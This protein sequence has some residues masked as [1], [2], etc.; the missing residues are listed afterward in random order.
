MNRPT[1]LLM[2]FLVTSCASGGE[3]IQQKSSL[4]TATATKPMDTNSS[5]GDIRVS[6]EL[7]TINLD[8]DD[9]QSVS[10][11][12]DRKLI[13]TPFKQFFLIDLKSDKEEAAVR[14]GKIVDTAL[15]TKNINYEIKI[16]KA[17]SAGAEQN[18]LIKLRSIHVTPRDCSPNKPEV[19]ATIGS[20]SEAKFGCSYA[21]NISAMIDNPKDI[22]APRGSEAVVAA[23]TMQILRSYIDGKATGSALPS[24]E[25]GEASAVTSSE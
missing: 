21:N 1:I 5:F 7:L 19:L 13:E 16:N 8:T 23:R 4:K 10:A 11:W 15:R 6:E 20:Y 2:V 18:I 17:I 25:G 12:V 9:A 22:I 24:T 14:F 3:S